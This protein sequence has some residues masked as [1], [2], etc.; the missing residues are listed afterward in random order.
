M[1]SSLL[2]NI[3]PVLYKTTPTLIKYRNP[4][5]IKKGCSTRSYQKKNHSRC[6]AP[7]FLNQQTLSD[8]Y[9]KSKCPIFHENELFNWDSNIVYDWSINFSDSH[10]MMYGELPK[11][12]TKFIELGYP[13]CM[14]SRWVEWEARF[15]LQ[16]E[17]QAKFDGY[18]KRG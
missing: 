5:T 14:F 11:I 1:W 4:S 9:K 2:K 8:R 7:N 18:R 6:C 15:K 17:R 13:W 12:G 10:R 3:Y 16:W